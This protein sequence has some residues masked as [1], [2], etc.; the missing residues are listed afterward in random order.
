[1]TLSEGWL[2]PSRENWE[3]L[4]K[5]WQFYPLVRL[6][7]YTASSPL[8]MIETEALRLICATDNYRAMVQRLLS[9]RQDEH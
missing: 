4:C 8:Q 5:V 1:M 2:P 3:L 7:Q 9:T 6:A